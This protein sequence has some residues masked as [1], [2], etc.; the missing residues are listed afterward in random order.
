[1]QNNNK[2]LKL[3]SKYLSCVDETLDNIFFFTFLFITFA[4]LK[5]IMH[6]DSTFF[7]AR[8]FD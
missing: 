2:T 6:E 4:Q 3:L 7:I 8:L 1:M 5:T